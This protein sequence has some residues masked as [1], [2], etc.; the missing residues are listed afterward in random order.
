MFK[1]KTFITSTDFEQWQYENANAKIFQFSP[2]IT[3][4]QGGAEGEKVDIEATFGCFVV[5][6]NRET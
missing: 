6:Q 5:Y 2:V 1:F 4:A 3:N